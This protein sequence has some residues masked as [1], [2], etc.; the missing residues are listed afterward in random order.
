M[1]FAVGSERHG[2][3]DIAGFHSLALEPGLDSTLGGC[4]LVNRAGCGL[5]HWQCCCGIFTRC[6][7]AF[8]IWLKV[9]MLGLSLK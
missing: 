9:P 5:L 2:G 7:R 3:A 4:W 6:K 8:Q 1:G